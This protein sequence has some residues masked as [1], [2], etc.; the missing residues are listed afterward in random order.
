[1]NT[2][3]TTPN[4]KRSDRVVDMFVK[5]IEARSCRDSLSDQYHMLM[6]QLKVLQWMDR[7]PADRLREI[8]RLRRECER[9]AAAWQ[10]AYDKC[11]RM[12]AK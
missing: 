8:K 10:K 9:T 1:M 6:D 2:K 5:R 12:G 4:A 7:T 3:T 11:E